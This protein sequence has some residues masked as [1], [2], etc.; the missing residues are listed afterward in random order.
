V[1][2]I[3]LN[4][5]RDGGLGIL[6]QLYCMRQ[7]ENHPNNTGIVTK[8]I[9][10]SEHRRNP[11]AFNLMAT[12]VEMAQRYDI[13]ECFMDCIPQLAPFFISIGFVQAGPPFLHNENGRSLPLRLD[14]NRYAK[15]IL[16]LTGLVV[17]TPS[18]KR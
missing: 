17:H 1:A 13:K 18:S 6:E 10:T 2:T 11:V 7:S 15:R 8:F 12:A 4:M 16:R 9:V 5:S 14:V 3:R